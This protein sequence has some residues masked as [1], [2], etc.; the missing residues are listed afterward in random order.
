MKGKKIAIIF[1]YDNTIVKSNI[2][3][4]AMK[5]AMAEYGDQT[6]NMMKQS[7]ESQYK[8]RVNQEVSKEREIYASHQSD[9]PTTVPSEKAENKISK[10]V[11]SE[12]AFLRK[13]R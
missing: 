5:I 9:R 2:D 7:L 10:I 8:A 3:F 11:E 6:I 4:P 1:D 12:T 13:R